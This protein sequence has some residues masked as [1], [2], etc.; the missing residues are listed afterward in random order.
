LGVRALGGKGKLGS[1]VYVG[2]AGKKNSVSEFREDMK[3]YNEKGV[4]W[5][6]EK[7]HTKT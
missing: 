5:K 2:G 7:L 3:K 1:G 4:K 6:L